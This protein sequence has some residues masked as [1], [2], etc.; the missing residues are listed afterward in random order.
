[1]ISFRLWSQLEPALTEF[2]FF[3]KKDLYDS[4]IHAFKLGKLSFPLEKIVFITTNYD[5]LFEQALKRA[6]LLQAP[7]SVLS[8]PGTSENDVVLLKIHGSANWVGNMGD[9]GPLDQNKPTPICLRIS[10][11]SREYM[12][13]FPDWKLDFGS[14]VQL[15]NEII[16]AHY[17][18]DKPAHVN[19]SLI[20]QIRDRAIQHVKLCERAILLG[21]HLEERKDADPCLFEILTIVRDRSVPVTYVG[22]AGPDANKAKDYYKFDVL[23]GGFA[24][25]LKN[26]R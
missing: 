17:A 18:I 13:I 7:E 14:L 8:W 15:G 10:S 24:G 12:N 26:L 4:L 3:E 5:I 11:S 23:T 1:M 16:M 19:L 22:I 21:V 9:G 6:N 25:F 2:P 20:K